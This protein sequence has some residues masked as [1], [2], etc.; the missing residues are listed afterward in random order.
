MKILGVAVA[1]F[2][3]MSAGVGLEFANTT[4]DLVAAA[5][6]I[7]GYCCWRSAPVSRFLKMFLA[8]FAAE[9]IVFGLA[10][11]A[12]RFGLWP[13]SLAEARMPPTLALTVALFAIIVFVVSHIPV[14]R[15]LTRIADRFFLATDQTSTGIGGFRFK[16]L[17]RTLATA[18]VIFLV[19]LN[20]AEVA[21][22]VRLNFFNRDFFNAIQN[23]NGPEFCRMLLWVF[24]PWAFI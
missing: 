23:H 20:Q 18:M 12:A 19:L 22:T 13:K 14:V 15:T 1:L 5:S 17:E 21:I 2:G 6:L 16:T 3:L 4:L 7:V 11:L 8:L 24:T 10:D 9:T